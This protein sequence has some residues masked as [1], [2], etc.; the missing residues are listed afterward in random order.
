MIQERGE[1]DHFVH[2]SAPTH[3]M[4]KSIKRPEERESLS[5]GPKHVKLPEMFS[6][7]RLRRC[8]FCHDTSRSGNSS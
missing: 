8:R 3:L 1:G 5:Y 6:G 4:R 7:M 2:C